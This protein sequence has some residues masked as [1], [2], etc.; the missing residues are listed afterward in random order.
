MKVL[1]ALAL[2]ISLATASASK[3]GDLYISISLT[4]TEHGRD[5]SST[6]TTFTISGNK[7]VSEETYGGEKGGARE[8]QEKENVPAGPEGEKIYRLIYQESI[9]RA[10]GII[11][12]A[13]GACFYT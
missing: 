12:P 1:I 2:L 8:N 4:I 9:I 3:P 11:V 10:P 5:S 6:K 13:R 7:I